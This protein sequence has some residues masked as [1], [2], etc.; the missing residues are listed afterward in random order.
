MKK[1]LF[2]KV[3]A[4]F[5]FIWLCV[6]LWSNIIVVMNVGS[7]NVAFKTNKLTGSTYFLRG[8]GWEKRPL[9]SK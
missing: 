7:N 9:E 6:W 5:F 1:D 2:W 3:M 4:V 8:D